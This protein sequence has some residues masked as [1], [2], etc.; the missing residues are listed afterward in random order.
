MRRSP[1][2]SFAP[3]ALALGTAAGLLLAAPAA[4]D[5]RLEKDLAL[6]PGG[7]LVV[8]TAGGS[9][10]VT[11]GPGTG[12]HVVVTSD[13]DRADVEERYTFDF[14]AEPGRV[15]IV[16]KRRS[17][18]SSWFN[19]R[20][21]ALHFEIQVPRQTRVDLQSSGG[22]LRV[23]NLDGDAK[24]RSSGGAV[25]AFDLVGRVDASS[26]GGGVDVRRVR[27]N[28]RVGSSGGGVDVVQ[29]IGD[30]AAESSGGGVDVSEVTGAV[31]ASSSGGG[32]HLEKIGGRV[33]AESSGGPVSAELLADNAAGGHFSSSGGG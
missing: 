3:L 14:T 29:I 2:F 20:G 25:R 1:S 16:N 4:A 31:D 18:F 12:A 9:V 13:R 28:V 17:Q 27:G 22:G 7:E 24:L 5:Y 21:M 23:S 33:T 19:W 26:S 30:V 15:K 32:V 11:G 10:T 6:A 8:E